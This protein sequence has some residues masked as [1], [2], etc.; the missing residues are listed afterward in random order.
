[1]FIFISTATTGQNPFTTTTN[2]NSFNPVFQGNASQNGDVLLG[3]LLT[4]ER[5]GGPNQEMKPTASNDNDTKDLSSSLARAAKSLGMVCFLLS[6]NAVK[7]YTDE[8]P[9]YSALMTIAI[10]YH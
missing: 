1:M 3:D 7:C 8:E 6:C 9:I 10:D 2:N 5:V 4:P